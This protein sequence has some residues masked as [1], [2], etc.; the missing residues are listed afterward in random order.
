MHAFCEQLLVMQQ[1]RKEPCRFCGALVLKEG[2]IYAHLMDFD[3]PLSNEEIIVQ[4]NV[5]R[6]VD[7]DSKAAGQTKVIDDQSE[8]YDKNGNS[9]R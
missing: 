3:V 5:K 7:Y 2:N 4:D 9:S 1:E 6:L 8:Y